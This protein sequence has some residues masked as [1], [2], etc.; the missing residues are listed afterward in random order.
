MLKHM[1]YLFVAYYNYKSHKA[2]VELALK[3]V[4]AYK[5]LL[6]FDF[7]QNK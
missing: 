5:E 2:R 1:H 7:G 3:T 4:C 6:V